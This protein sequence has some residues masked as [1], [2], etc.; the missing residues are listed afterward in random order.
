MPFP[1]AI[2]VMCGMIA[3]FQR[4]RI[5]CPSFHLESETQEH[6]DRAELDQIARNMQAQYLDAASMMTISDG[7]RRANI[8]TEL[9]TLA[10]Q[11]RFAG[12]DIAKDALEKLSKTLVFW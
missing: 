12:G 8:K 5:A 1:L 7:K 6:S 4:E 9:S 10:L 11:Q 3:L 2:A